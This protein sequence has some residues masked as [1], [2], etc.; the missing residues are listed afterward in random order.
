[1]A[2]DKSKEL[3]SIFSD[4]QKQSENIEKIQLSLDK[5]IKAFSAESSFVDTITYVLNYEFIGIA[6]SYWI[7]FFILTLI[8]SWFMWKKITKLKSHNNKKLN[9]DSKSYLL[10]AGDVN[11]RTMPFFLLVILL[12]LLFVEASGFSYVFSEF[13]IN[14]ASES[15]LQKT[16]IFGGFVLSIVLMFL[17]H[18]SGEEIHKMSVLKAI[19]DEMASTNKEIIIQEKEKYPRNKV[20]LELNS[21]DDTAKTVIIPQYNRIAQKYFDWRNFKTNRRFFLTIFTTIFI[22]SIGIGAM[23]VRFY[24]F[25]KNIDYYQESQIIDSNTFDVETHF[26]KEKSRGVIEKSENNPDTPSYFNTQAELR[27]KYRRSSQVEAEKRASYVTYAVMMM[28]FFGI[29]VVGLISGI[30]YSFMG[31]ESKKAYKLIKAYKEIN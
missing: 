26:L 16:M 10:K 17:T 12:G 7:S 22:L 19:D 11:R 13:M 15:M 25:D 31:E 28:L 27:D 9:E 8:V 21:F 23:F 6:I 14:D 29:Q 30:R 20:N 5:E 18:F 4:Y 1:M 24:V 2:I 3:D